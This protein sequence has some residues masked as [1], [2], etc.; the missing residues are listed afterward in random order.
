MPAAGTFGNAGRNLLKG[1]AVY[2]W[3]FSLFKN[4]RVKEGQTLQFRAEMFNI[5][6]TPQFHIPSADISSP[7]TFGQSFY[8]L[9]AAGGFWSNRQI[10]FALRY[11]F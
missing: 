10:Q 4:F 2:N 9:P 3:D 5:F 11:N 7:A 8:I 1:P 6:N